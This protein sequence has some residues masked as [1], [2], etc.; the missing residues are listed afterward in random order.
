[1][2]F[3]KNTEFDRSSLIGQS[4]AQNRGF[5]SR[6]MLTLRDEMQSDLNAYLIDWRRPIKKETNNSEELEE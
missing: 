6:F 4:P 1:M 3:I 5:S 2:G